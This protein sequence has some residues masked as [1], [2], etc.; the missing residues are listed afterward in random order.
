MNMAI[1]DRQA[2]L[3]MAHN[4]IHELRQLVEYFHEGC[5]IYI[6]IDKKYKLSAGSLNVLLS[7][8]G[9]RAVVQKYKTN[10]GSYNILRAELY[11]LSIS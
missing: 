10:W 6:H 11:L 1:K 4:N 3:I 8:K 7:M 5:D 2:I 9:V